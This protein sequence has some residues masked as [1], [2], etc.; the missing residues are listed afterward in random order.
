MHSYKDVGSRHSNSNFADH[1]MPGELNQRPSLIYT[2]YQHEVNC[3]TVL[4]RELMHLL[5]NLKMK[6]KGMLNQQPQHKNFLI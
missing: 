1:L 3:H 5:I 4:G 2:K 6:V